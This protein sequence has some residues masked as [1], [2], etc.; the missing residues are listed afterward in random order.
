MEKLVCMRTSTR[1][2]T[3]PGGHYSCAGL[4]WAELS[5]AGLG[6][7]SKVSSQ[8]CCERRRQYLVANLSARPLL[9]SIHRPPCAI[10]SFSS[11]F[12]F[13]PFFFLSEYLVLYAKYFWFNEKPTTW[14]RIHLGFGETR[15]RREGTSDD[16]YDGRTTTTATMCAS[17]ET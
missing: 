8:Y 10:F 12:C 13:S 11:K 6:D 1:S 16:D 4:G 2:Q 17:S 7:Q 15:R 14:N 5:W 9:F 3:Q